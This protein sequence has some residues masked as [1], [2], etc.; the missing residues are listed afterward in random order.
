MSLLSSRTELL[1]VDT[2]PDGFGVLV[3]KRSDHSLI[4]T[5]C[6]NSAKRY[7]SDGPEKIVHGA[8]SGANY[9]GG[10]PITRGGAH[11]VHLIP[12]LAMTG[13]IESDVGVPGTSRLLTIPEV[14]AALRISRS[15]IYRLFEAGELA[16]VQIGAARRVTSAE[17]NRFVAKHIE[18]AS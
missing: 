13:H 4:I 9:S 16:W 7:Y 14:A 17:V 8:V 6:A 1:D 11:D 15:S 10:T 2:T 12:E 3:A 18:A 5:R